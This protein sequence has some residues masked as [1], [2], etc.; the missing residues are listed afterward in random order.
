M[1]LG[2]S[3]RHRVCSH[4]VVVLVVLGA[5]ARR[6]SGLWQVTQADFTFAGCATVTLCPTDDIAGL[7]HEAWVEITTR[8][9][10]LPFDDEHDVVVE[11]YSSWYELFRALREVAKNC[12]LA[13]VSGRTATPPS[14][15]RFLPAP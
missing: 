8:K 9:A 1:G 3:L 5:V 15:S 10:A 11:V 6:R 7:A 4:L 2:R 13:R 14:S 12:R